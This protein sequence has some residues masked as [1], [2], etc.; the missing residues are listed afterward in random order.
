MKLEK[1]HTSQNP[2]DMLTKVVKMKMKMK[3]F[4]KYRVNW[5]SSMKVKMRN[6]PS[7]ELEDSPASAVAVKLL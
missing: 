4:A 5:P 1:Q 6:L 2:A 3:K 7:P